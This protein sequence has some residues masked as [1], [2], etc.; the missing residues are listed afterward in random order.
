M[1]EET[2]Q[3]GL[4]IDVDASSIPE[5]VKSAFDKIDQDMQRRGQG[6]GGALEAR[7]AQTLERASALTGKVSEQGYLSK[8]EKQELE[9]TLRSL[10]SLHKR[11]FKERLQESQTLRG[12]YDQLKKSYDAQ[13]KAYTEQKSPQARAVLRPELDQARTRVNALAK[14]ILTPQDA[15]DEQRKAIQEY[16][17]RAALITSQESHAHARGIVSRVADII[18]RGVMNFT[19]G[20][21]GIGGV[22]GAGLGVRGLAGG[23]GGLG[24]GGG[25]GGSSTD[26][27]TGGTVGVAG[28]A[29]MLASRGLSILGG[30]ALG[31]GAYKL[32][33]K[34][35]DAAT[36]ERGRQIEVADQ[37]QRLRPPGMTASEMIAGTRDLHPTL[38]PNEA[39]QFF[40]SYS[41]LAGRRSFGQVSEAASLTRALGFAPEQGAHVFGQ[42][43]RLGIG[44]QNLFQ[45][46]AEEIANAKMHGREGEMYEALLHMAEALTER[47]GR[48]DVEQ[49]SRVLG[50]MS[51][52]G[53]PGLQGTMGAQSALRV[54]EAFRQAPLFN[55]PDMRQAVMFMTMSNLGITDPVEMLRVR[56]RGLLQDS[57]TARGFFKTID[58]AGGIDSLLGTNAAQ[59]FG[60]SPLPEVF[61]AQR[62]AFTDPK[63]PEQFKFL[64]R[65]MG[66]QGAKDISLQNLPRALE[67]AQ[68]FQEREKKGVFKS[69]TEMRAEFNKVL[70]TE[71]SIMMTEFEARKQSVEGIRQWTEA[72]QEATRLFNLLRESLNTLGEHILPPFK[73]GLEGITSRLEK[74]NEWMDFLFPGSSTKPEGMSSVPVPSE[75]YIRLEKALRDSTP[76]DARTAAI[77]GEGIGGRGG[78]ETVWSTAS[79]AW[80]AL[81]DLLS[82]PSSL[83]MS[84]AEERRATNARAS[85]KTGVSAEII[86]QIQQQREQHM[87]AVNLWGLAND[88]W[89]SL[90]SSAGETGNVA[91]RASAKTRVPVKEIEQLMERRGLG[92]LLA[93]ASQESGVS[94]D[95]LSRV[96][97]QESSGN[98]NAKSKKGALGLM[99]LMPSSFPHLSEEEILDPKINVPTGAK[100]LGKQIRRF[101]SEE[102]GLAAYNMG[103]TALSRVL[104]DHPR[105]WRAHLYDETKEYLRRI[106]GSGKKESEMTSPVRILGSEGG[107][108]SEKGELGVTGSLR[109]TV[110]VNHP[111]GSR[112]QKTETVQSGQGLNFDLTRAAPGGHGLHAQQ[113]SPHLGR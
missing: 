53:L 24:G 22:T 66:E 62:K 72:V 31:Y 21:F 96:M 102:K 20:A 7:F 3:V 6:F 79:G 90:S 107:S 75:D 92:G 50:G 104:E 55:M 63:A 28:A 45:G 43:E 48:V 61:A 112:T 77:I 51:A 57:K 34:V 108:R 60:L 9:Q 113:N 26:D 47:L 1:A 101:G 2:I 38:T 84:E 17:D 76:R 32:G 33:R 19:R 59:L 95:L 35:F 99:Q 83:A 4:Q 42:A 67:V 30:V 13:L 18:G 88:A 100:Y 8:G 36:D 78:A 14:Q 98:P 94:V 41:A 44:Q 15:Y 12:E 11:Y 111:D 97:R 40:G 39:T 56:E 73:A 82:P 46:L 23:R 69:E 71:V 27:T 103:P 110:D 109:L 58:D 106:L 54:D 37:S 16:R 81:K 29:G 5:G 64:Q 10:D 49:M 52:S 85:A 74:I 89:G 86:E 87:G 70:Q 91:T 68:S 80:G 65:M 93:S 25:D 105:D